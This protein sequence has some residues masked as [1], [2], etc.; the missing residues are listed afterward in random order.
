MRDTAIATGVVHPHCYKTTAIYYPR[1]E[2]E[3][4]CNPDY[5]RRDD[6]LLNAV[7]TFLMFKMNVW[8]GHRHMLLYTTF[9]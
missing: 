8:A 2:T 9:Y 1:D 3:Q 4:V 7:L 6:C 5:R